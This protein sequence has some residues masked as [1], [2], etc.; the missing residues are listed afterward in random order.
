MSQESE[1]YSWIRDQYEASKKYLTDKQ[2]H[3]ASAKI[4]DAALS[5]DALK[6]QIE[7]QEQAE[8][9]ARLSDN[10]DLLMDAIDKKQKNL[11]I[12]QRTIDGIFERTDNFFQ[13]AA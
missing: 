13:K 7:N 2:P 6:T 1:L 5:L 12:L 10:L 4:F 9:L 11:R 8:L 3:T